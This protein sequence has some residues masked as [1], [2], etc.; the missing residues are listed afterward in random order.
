LR[1]Q[2]INFDK[3]K[4]IIES[5]NSSSEYYDDRYRS[6]QLEK[7]ELAFKGV[8][9]QS[10]LILDAGCGTGLLYTHI[11]KKFSN[12][13]KTQ[14]HYICLDISFN[15]VKK[16][17]IKEEFKEEMPQINLI[18]SD[19]ENLPFR[20]KIFDVIVSITS[21]QNL[22]N[23]FQ[24]IL[25]LMRVSKRKTE[26]Y[27]SILKK[28]ARLEEVISKFKPYVDDFTIINNEELEDLIIQGKIF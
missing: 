5:Y 18:L 23:I 19:M 14:S 4:K 26:F 15:M 17:K 7:F 13:K 22:P 11:S 2:Q 3:K 9:F 24:G 27:L 8:N 1:D 10:K 25:E 6:L 28:D 16:V 12:S 20:E 21:L